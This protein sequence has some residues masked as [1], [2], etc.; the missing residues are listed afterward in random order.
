MNAE[1]RP[2][3]KSTGA[4]LQRGSLS[5]DPVEKKIKKTGDIIYL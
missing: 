1:G 3:D 2:R 4:S 5:E